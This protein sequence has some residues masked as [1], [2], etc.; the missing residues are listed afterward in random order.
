MDQTGLLKDWSKV[1]A[2]GFSKNQSKTTQKLVQTTKKPGF[3]CILLMFF[4]SNVCQ[5]ASKY[6]VYTVGIMYKSLHIY[7]CHTS[8]KKI[9]FT[10][11]K[12]HCRPKLAC[13]IGV[14]IPYMYCL[15]N[16]VATG[17]NWSF[18]SFSKVGNW[19]LQSSCDWSSP[20]QF[21]VFLWSYGLDFKTLMVSTFTVISRRYVTS[22]A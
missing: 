6:Y 20:V 4:T 17:C 19:Q 12:T 21:P 5:I 7:L 14:F 11:L 2:T 8:S 9:N 10:P 16:V 1:V 15:H 22:S 13:N 3:F 18:S